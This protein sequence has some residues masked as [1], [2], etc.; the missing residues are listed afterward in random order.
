MIAKVIPSNHPIGTAITRLN[1]KESMKPFP[2]L[3]PAKKKI[4]AES[5]DKAPRNFLA[6]RSSTLIG[7][8]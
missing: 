1:S 8:L 5:K 7:E 3:I 4:I 2:V 6:F